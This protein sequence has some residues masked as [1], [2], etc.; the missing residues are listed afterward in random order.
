MWIKLSKLF[1]IFLLIYYGWFQ[2]VF[3]QVP[4]MLLILGVGM[5]GFIIIHSL[6]TREKILTMVTK[7]L[8]YWFLFLITS[9]VFGSIVAIK[10]DYLITS[11][12]TFSQFW[13][14]MFGIVYISK[15]DRKIDFFINIFILFVLICAF[16]TVFRGVNYGNGRITMGYKNN[17]N[18]LGITMAIGVSCILYKID[19]KRI[20]NICLS[21]GL[22]FL[23]I[24]VT[25]LTG[26][27]KSFLSIVLIV[28]WWF[29]FV[30]II[31]LKTLKLSQK[32][33]GVLLIGAVISIGYLILYPIFN[34]SV[35][36][37][38]LIDLF[39]SGSETRE[40]M[41]G[42]AFDLFERSPFIGIGLNNYRAVTIYE[43][44]SH[45]T[46]AEALA[47]T[48]IIGSLLYFYPYVLMVNNYRKIIFCKKFDSVLIKQS[49]V[50][51]GLLG[52]MIFLGI[53]IIHFYELTS[54]IAFGMIIAFYRVNKENLQR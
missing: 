22:I 20:A 3:F 42:V 29:A 21:C 10:T 6:Q 40:G 52:V 31:D 19:F 8:V 14:L 11:V 47:C 32:I 15:Q 44:Y 23:F 49:R 43:T 28:L 13:L 25:L 1:Y 48:G 53:G 16:T 50:I 12:I 26:S 9:F 39:Q 4:N 54:S 18:T 45:S 2:V 33:N 36:L 37:L 35:L 17:P 24:Y 41:Y 38:R 51:L 5:I 34:E 7:E 46:Y 30:V 27:R